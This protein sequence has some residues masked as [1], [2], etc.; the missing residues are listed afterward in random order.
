MGDTFLAD[1]AINIAPA[2]SMSMAMPPG[3]NGEPASQVPD[4][5]PYTCQT[6]TRRKVKCDKLLPI[7][8]TCSK[9]KLDCSYQAPPPR[10]RKRKPSEDLNG[11]LA[12]YER[13]L[14]QHGLLTESSTDTSP[15]EHKEARP[16]APNAQ[17][18]EP[19]RIGRLL[20]GEGTTRYV[21]SNLWRNLGEEEM[22]RIAD[23]EAD[24]ADDE[25]PG[26]LSDGYALP[27]DPFSCAFLG[28]N[29][30]LRDCHPTAA[31]AERLWQIHTQNVEPICKV[32]HIPS[33]QSL[34]NN[35]VAYP[36]FASKVDECILFAVYHFAVTSLDDEECQQT[37]GQP[38]SSIR[39][40]YNNSLKQ[41]FINVSFLKTTQ[42][43]VLQAFLLYLLSQRHQL[44]PHT[45]WMLT[46]T[47]VRIA[48]RMGIHRD[49]E[50]LGLS[51]FDVQ[52]RRRLWYQLISLDGYA[53]QI[54]GTGITVEPGTWDSKQP[55]NINDDQI[56]PGMT[57]QPEEQNGATDMIFFLARA[58]MGAWYLKSIDGKSKPPMYKAFSYHGDEA[59]HGDMV[60][61]M[62]GVV[63]MK[64]IR[65]CDLLNPLHTLL[66]GM[67]R[68]AA[69]AARLRMKLPSLRKDHVSNEERKEV[70]RIAARIIDTDSAAHTNP[71]LKRYMWH[72]KAF[73]QWDALVC[74]L[75]SMAKP[76]LFSPSELEESWRRI[77]HVFAN[78]SEILERNRMLNTAV[79][80]IT[81]KAWNANPPAFALNSE[82][83]FIQALRALYAEGE[84][85]RRRQ[86]GRTASTTEGTGKIPPFDPSPSGDVKAL[87]Q[88]PGGMALN[89]DNDFTLDNADWSF[90]ESLIRGHSNLQ[91][92]QFDEFLS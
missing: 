71:S 50:A 38:R 67:A 36:Q 15:V 79:G 42:M 51:P 55:V 77:E 83:S 47:A 58:E 7:C 8:S 11:K 78:H 2:P 54:S 65:Y 45:F 56:W 90:W 61:Q 76:D 44:D 66:M 3:P 14:H 63:E 19:N 16:V 12:H 46:G 48:Q 21:D 60:D 64:Y 74:M 28:V 17:S 62:E 1:R 70:C 87:E 41:A 85:K 33:V 80:R 29:R 32:L 89:L 39:A 86:A 23:D 92:D 82:P 9:A 69:N 26:S 91:D 30:S 13:I 52:M 5:M 10:K 31:D 72:I 49:G 4:S 68:S 18:N 81:L 59:A 34:I 53:S 57:H 20:S 25:I 88:Y 40:H 75:I 43:P 73:F 6:C 84:E 35:V 22:N 37:L 24:E 27:G